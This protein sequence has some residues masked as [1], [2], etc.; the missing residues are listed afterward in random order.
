MRDLKE[1]F[2]GGSYHPAEKG[3]DTQGGYKE[4]ITGS[5]IEAA[6]TPDGLRKLIQS[7]RDRLEQS[8]DADERRIL[9][10]NIT[11]WTEA[12]NMLEK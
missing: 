9:D 6:S 10:G 12:L 5:D 7:A 4:P 2:A 3:T 1:I 8:D 11:K